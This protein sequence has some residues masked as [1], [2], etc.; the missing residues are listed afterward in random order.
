MSFAIIH[1]GHTDGH[2]TK[3]YS[4]QP[5]MKT[6]RSVFLVLPEPFSGCKIAYQHHTASTTETVLHSICLSG[7]SSKSK[8]Q[9]QESEHWEG[10]KHMTAT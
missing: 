5:Q 4:H 1:R 6:T 8:E 9:K 2:K 10:L 7:I 3:E